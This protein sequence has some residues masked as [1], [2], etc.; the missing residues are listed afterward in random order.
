MKEID[1]LILQDW[2][3]E[4][5]TNQDLDNYN[6]MYELNHEDLLNQ[7]MLYFSKNITIEH[8]MNYLKQFN[9]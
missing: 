5:Y 9:K 7:H 4:R 1:T 3:L 8:C 6:Y 2:T